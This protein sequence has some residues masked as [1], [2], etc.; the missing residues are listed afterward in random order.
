MVANIVGALAGGDSIEDIVD[1]YPNITLE[2]VHAA[3][4]YAEENNCKLNN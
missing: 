2:D 1:D 3:I 4:K